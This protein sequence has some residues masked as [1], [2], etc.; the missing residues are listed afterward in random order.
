MTNNM[1]WSVDVATSCDITIGNISIYSS[2]Q[3]YTCNPL[4]TVLI[5]KLHCDDEVDLIFSTKI[6]VIN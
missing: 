1:T 5:L 3:F 2:W 6:Y 4:N